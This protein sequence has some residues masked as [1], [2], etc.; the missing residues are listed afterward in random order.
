MID[1]ERSI[2]LHRRLAGNTDAMA[3]AEAFVETVAEHP[4]IPADAG[5]MVGWFANAIEA[6]RAAG[7]ATADKRLG[8][9]RGRL[10][11]VAQDLARH[12]RETS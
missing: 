7:L 5:A 2:E 1:L 8:E 9:V 11:Q 3:W 12:V 10:V 6:G 4:E